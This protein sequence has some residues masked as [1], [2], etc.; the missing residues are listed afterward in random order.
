MSARDDF[1]SNAGTSRGY[2]GGA[3]GLGN[4][5]V[6]GGMGGGFQGGGAARNGG[7]GSSTGLTTGNT[8]HGNSAFGR[9]GGM[10]QA[11]GMRDAR[12]LAGAGMGPTMGTYG[13]FKTL[14]GNPMFAG[15]P[16]QNMMYRGPNMGQALGQAQLAQAAWQNVQSPATGG[17]L[18]PST[19]NVQ[20]ASAPSTPNPIGY[21]P[22]WPGTGQWWGEAG[23][24]PW[25][26]D[27]R[28]WPGTKVDPLGKP[29]PGSNSMTIGGSYPDPRI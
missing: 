19:P 6:G 23:L 25:N 1:G 15:S 2:A 16:I 22:G 4:G 17:L 8:W 26:N 13:Q 29:A 20:P 21:L 18:G 9:A 24:N 11:Y 27:A 14:Q 7:I 5:G 28:T 10:A 12:S 3:G